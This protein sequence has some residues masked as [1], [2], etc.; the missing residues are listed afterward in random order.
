MS[1][2]RTAALRRL[3]NKWLEATKL[4]PAKVA[5]LPLRE[6][7]TEDNIAAVRALDLYPEHDEGATRRRAWAVA[8]TLR[9]ERERQQRM[10]R[11]WQSD[12]RARVLQ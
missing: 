5:Q 4:D 10:L 1:V 3:I 7:L 2:S 9:A 12:P 8:N 11:A 6:I